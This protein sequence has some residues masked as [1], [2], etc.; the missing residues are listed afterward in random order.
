MDYNRIRQ[1]NYDDS[2][3]LWNHCASLSGQ[4]ARFH[5]ILLR[6]GEY[7]NNENEEP[8][9]MA[10]PMRMLRFFLFFYFYFYF[11]ILILCRILHSENNQFSKSFNCWGMS[12]LPSIA[13][14]IWS[15]VKLERMS[16]F[17]KSC[18]LYMSI[19]LWLFKPRSDLS[20]K[21]SGKSNELPILL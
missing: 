8:R 18:L 7:L 9:K 15:E 17:S 20:N 6:R 4:V 16:A 19:I 21:L 1:I 5:S 10:S 11:N 2:W 3:Q 13:S 12:S 14:F